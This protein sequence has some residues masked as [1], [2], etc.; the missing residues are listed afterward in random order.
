VANSLETFTGF[1]DEAIVVQS[2]T[3]TFQLFLEGW[4]L[5]HEGPMAR[6][7]FTVEGEPS[8]A[9]AIIIERPDVAE[10]KPFCSHANRCGFRVSI[11]LT[12][13]QKTFRVEFCARLTT[14]SLIRST[15][16][17]HPT[18]SIP[19]LKAAEHIYQQGIKEAGRK[20]DANTKLPDYRKE[21]ISMCS[22]RYRNFMISGEQLA[23]PRS[24]RVPLS[25]IIPVAGQEHLTYAC[26]ENLRAL[27]S[28]DLEIILVDSSNSPATQELVSRFAGIKRIINQGKHSF[29][30]ACNLGGQHAAGELLLFLNNDAFPLPGALE[31]ALSCLRQNPDC[32]AVGAKIIRPDG[33]I[34]EVG[35][36]ILPTGLTVHRGRGAAVDEPMFNVAMRVD[37]CSASFLLTPKQIFDEH[38]G[39][40]ERF[41]P[42]YYEDTD[43][44]LRVSKAGRPCVVEPRAVVLHLERGTTD[45]TRN[46]D[47]LMTENLKVFQ[48]LHPEFNRAPISTDDVTNTPPRRAKSRTRTKYKTAKHPTSILVIDD[49]LPESI[50]GQGQGRSALIL[51]TLS[52]LNVPVS[53]YPALDAPEND[54]ELPRN[55]EI[56]RPAKDDEEISFLRRILSQFDTVLV[57][58]PH[59]MERLQIALR[60]LPSMQKT[61]RIIYDAEAVQGTR[62]ILK[63]ELCNN[64]ILSSDE[65]ETILSNEII[66]A[67]DADQILTTSSLEATT[68]I[69]FGFSS[70]TILSYGVTPHPSTPSFH[71]RSQFLSVGPMLE[72]N[73]PN[74]DAVCWFVQ[75]IFPYIVS[76]LQTS[77]IALHAVGDCSVEEIIS[78][79]GMNFKLLGRIRDMLP[80][81]SHYRVMVAPTRFSAGIPLK[82]IE[83]A[84]Y[85][86]PCVVTPAIAR[87]LDW[88]DEH[89][90]LVGYDAADFAAKCAALYRNEEL[91]GRIRAA[92]LE[93]VR[94]QFSVPEFKSSLSTTVLNPK[95]DR[96]S[97]RLPKA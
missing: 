4:I 50:E 70:P 66:L 93:R 32:G 40:D 77:K 15:I 87:Q 80:V 96:D 20:R 5:A 83:A 42:A 81:Y 37:Y 76:L 72:R 19:V 90:L 75:S 13:A 69:D 54:R 86:V 28:S 35:A 27:N 59:H 17:I 68:F 51:E 8:H 39:F 6:L 24:Y 45:E 92:A 84:S 11:P 65:I 82:V 63:F 57:S 97:V 12:K 18:L 48:S 49:A 55:I 26:L 56:V 61:P 85:G 25:I 1:V 33:R 16:D 29:S 53:W 44:C 7:M 62:E 38:G 2:T 22:S 43:Y 58:R 46:L 34:Q 41:D 52:N 21:L 30:H 78:M 9:E 23:L 36:F 60:S 74:S 67:R 79:Q 73:S 94:E 3:G 10:Q 71:E 91:W 47:V 14:G 89:E 88:Q 31:A 64:M 95:S